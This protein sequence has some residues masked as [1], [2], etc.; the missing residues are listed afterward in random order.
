MIGSLII[1]TFNITLALVIVL[2]NYNIPHRL[3]EDRMILGLV[4]MIL[5]EMLI[6]WGMQVELTADGSGRSIRFLIFG[7]MYAPIV[8]LPGSSKRDGLALLSVMFHG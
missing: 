4:F 5:M 7:L 8:F 3:R 2:L 6:Q 1:Y